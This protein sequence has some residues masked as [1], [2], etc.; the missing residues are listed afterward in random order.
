LLVA[1]RFA[2]FTSELEDLRVT[3]GGK[4]GGGGGKKGKGSR[5]R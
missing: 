3:K 4:G 1:D 2:E 5:K